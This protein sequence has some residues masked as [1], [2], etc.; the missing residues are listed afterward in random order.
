[1]ASSHQFMT[2]WNPQRFISWAESIDKYVKEF[3]CLILDKKQH[4]EQSYKSCLGILS[5]EKKYT[6]KRLINACTMAL[7]FGVYNYKIVQNI[8][9][10][11]M[12]MYQ[13]N[14]EEETPEMPD[15][16]NIRGENYYK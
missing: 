3:I 12:D 2:D 10:K 5:L 14:T 7:E 8:L 4:P 13:I 1:M 6:R 11:E 15:H 9:E 16:Q